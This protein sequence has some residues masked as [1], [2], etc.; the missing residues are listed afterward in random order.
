LAGTGNADFKDYYD[1]L[2]GYLSSRK[3][4]Y[5]T[6]TPN[7]QGSLT[8]LNTDTTTTATTIN[9][10]LDSVIALADSFKALIG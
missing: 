5:S 10:V 6:A 2:S 8:S 1:S 3:A 4:L 9:A 7:L